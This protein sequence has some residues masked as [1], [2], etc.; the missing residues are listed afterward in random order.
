M[1]DIIMLATA[2]IDNPYSSTAVSLAKEFAKNNRVFFVENPFTFRDIFSKNKR[3][4]SKSEEISQQ[5]YATQIDDN[6]WRITSDTV[7]SINWLPE[8]EL[9]NYLS[10]INEK[11]FFRVI[12]NL[13]DDFKIN[14]FILFNIFNPFY[15]LN[16][17]KWFCP[18]LSIYY[19]VDSISDAK[20][21]SKHGVPKENRMLQTFDLVLATSKPIYEKIK[22]I[23]KN[24]YYLPNGADFSL[25]GE[26]LGVPKAIPEDLKAIPEPRAIYIGNI[27]FRIDIE[28]IEQLLIEKPKINL[29][30]IGPINSKDISMLEK[31]ENLYMLGSRRIEM[32]PSYLKFCQCAIIPFIRNGFTKSIYPLKIN[33]YLANG[34]PTVT[35]AFS[36]SMI[37]FENIIS[38]CNSSK[39]FINAVEKG[40]IEDS[41]SLKIERI[42]YASNNSWESRA[43]QFWEIIDEFKK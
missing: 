24:A 28:L 40:V 30:F 37:E 8:G 35:T 17:P 42:K 38:V 23:N 20:Y 13:I 22:L 2:R 19:S 3:V 33:E 10:K 15:T 25:F 41:E 6:L 31:Y 5:E 21:F 27:D 1:S 32:L 4:L 9:Y 43:K 11:I 14:Q 34:M 26:N 18:E 36:D 7:L 39:D 16:F 29:V 12:K